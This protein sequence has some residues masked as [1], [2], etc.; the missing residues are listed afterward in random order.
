MEPEEK[1]FSI[2]WG[3]RVSLAIGGLFGFGVLFLTTI[4]QGLKESLYA[5]F[6]VFCIVFAVLLLCWIVARHGKEEGW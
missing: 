3:I 6:G 5:G 2:P 4:S 1:G